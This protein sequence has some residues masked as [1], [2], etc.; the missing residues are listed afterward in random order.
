MK[1]AVITAA[2]AVAAMGQALAED[3]GSINIPVLQDTAARGDAEAQNELGT[4]YAQGHGVTKNLDIAAM[5]YRK[6]AEQG[7]AN[8][9]YKLGWCYLFGKGVEIDRVEGVKWCRRAAK[10]GHEKAEG[11]FQ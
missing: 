6:A 11:H 9:Q 3:T 2:F 10:Q 1:Y 4:R 7:D 8:G 5:W